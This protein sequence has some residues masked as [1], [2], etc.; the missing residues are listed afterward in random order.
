[1]IN[2]SHLFFHFW[3]SCTFILVHR[4]QYVLLSHHVFFSN[5]TK[6][7]SFQFILVISSGSWIYTQIMKHL[8]FFFFFHFLYSY[9]PY[10]HQH[11]L[12]PYWTLGL[13]TDECEFL[14]LWMSSICCAEIVWLD[15]PSLL[16][17][18]WI[19]PLTAQ[20][21]V[22]LWQG[23]NFISY[24]VFPQNYSHKSTS[25]LLLTEW[26]SADTISFHFLVQ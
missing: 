9:S 4:I 15:E 24:R 11:F 10:L 3:G 17:Q 18:A 8:V 7:Y 6:F 5:Y 25:C 20:V 26:S 16:Q 13:H 14:S 23:G 1:M 21:K 22:H 2:A 19:C 12:F